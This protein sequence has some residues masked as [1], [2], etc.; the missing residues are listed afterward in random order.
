MNKEFLPLCRPALNDNDMNAV[1]KV[2]QSGWITTGQQSHALETLITQHIGA[3]YAITL[4]SATAGMHL[5]LLALGIG[6]GDEVITPS[7]TW[8]STINMITLLG[9]K[10]VFVD[11]DPHTLMTDAERIGSLITSKT[12]LIIPVHYAGAPLD[13]DALYALSTRY[14]IPILEDAAHALGTY[15]KDRP[16][17]QTG[18]CIFSLHAIKNITTAEGG[19]F[20]TQDKALAE[21]IR[22]LRFHGLGVDA[23]DRQHQGRRPQAEV[24]E[25]GFKYNMPDLCAVL[26]IGQLQRI[27]SITQ[28]RQQLAKLYQNKLQSI[29]GI[30]PL[31]VPH[32]SHVHCWHLFIIRI[33]PQT[34]GL[35]RDDFI[36]ALKNH[37]IGAGIHFKA[38]HSQHYYQKL[39][40]DS[41]ND[42]E[43]RLPNTIINS[44]QICSL[45][46]FPDMTPEDVNR[47][48]STI[49]QISEQHHEA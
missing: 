34:F 42:I 48:I 8:V 19:I 12:K 7:L 41:L 49:I 36:E 46:L 13:L 44:E 45:P 30:T 20:T 39:Y 35:N 29:A 47:V 1:I 10:P 5:A 17:G 3:A 24:I 31:N 4:S 43:E 27:G 11:V 40:Q 6:P 23:F 26:A 2:L 32:Y 16:I 21:R 38:C 22:R 18:H 33:D 25:P 15:Y 14:N 37:N 9:A 28:K